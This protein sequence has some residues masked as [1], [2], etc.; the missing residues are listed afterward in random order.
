M[1][2]IA[3]ALLGI[4]IGA[5]LQYRFGVLRSKRE[6]NLELK[7]NAYTDFL[8]AVSE[9]IFAQR[10]QDQNRQSYAF[11]LM[12]EAKV[13]I[14]VYGEPQFVSSMADFWRLG[15]CFDRVDRC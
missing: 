12:V 1:E 15:A 13:R 3:V 5:I 14:C 7:A 4:L 8:K 11:S 9:T 6:R 2:K 10:S